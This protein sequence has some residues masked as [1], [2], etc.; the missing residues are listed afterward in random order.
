M[1][2]AAEYG[3]KYVI[4]RTRWGHFGLCGTEKALFRTRLPIT[5]LEQARDRL[6]RKYPDSGFDKLFF[7]ELQQ[8]IKAYFEGGYVVFNKDIPIV[9]DGLGG[10]ARKT[11]AA[12]RDV[13]FGRTISYGQLANKTASPG[14]ARA[15]GRVMANNPLPLIIP[16]HRVIC[17]DGR[18]GGFSA[19]GAVSLKK[20]LLN[21]EKRVVR[22]KG[23]SG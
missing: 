4:F 19:T 8:Q 15:V 5:D 3:T 13:P 6:I 14:A 2:A 16:C 11:L 7:K 1:A 18:L 22:K 17:S 10:F 20:K 9:L 23:Q 21:L 12:C